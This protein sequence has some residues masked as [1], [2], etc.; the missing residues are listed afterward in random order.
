MKLSSKILLP[1]A[2]IIVVLGCVSVFIINASFKSLKEMHI[3][4]VVDS[5]FSFVLTR[6][7][8][9]SK[10]AQETAALFA[11]SP[12]VLE[13]FKIA[14]SGNID[15]ERSPQ[16]Q[17][18]REQIR[19]V[20]S[21]EL[22]NYA[23]VSGSK[24]RLHFHMPNGRSLVRLWRKKQAKRNG[25]WVDI[26]DDLS[27][28]RN[29]VLDVNTKGKPLGG[30]EL[31]RGGF[32]IRGLVPV[33]DSSGEIL[34]SA[35]VLNSFSPILK[36]VEDAGISTMLFM[37][38]DML[39]TA[40]SLR[41][42]SKYPIIGEDYVLVSGVDKA[43]NLS[44]VNKKLL[45]KS[46]NEKVVI[47]HSTDAVATLPIHDYRGNQI[48]VLVGVIDLQKMAAMSQQANIVLFAC[49]TAMLLIPLC[50]IFFTLRS[51]VVAPV[52]EIA[53]KINDINED[54][55]DLGTLIDIKFKDEIGYMTGQF[56][57][58]LGKISTMVNEMEIYVD[59]VNAVPDPIFVVDDEYN[60][61]FA[62]KGV[63]DFSGL[64]PEKIKK[65]KCKDIFNSDVCSTGKCPLEK[66][67]GNENSDNVGIVELE[68]LSGQTLY[69]QPVARS[70]QDSKGK[71]IGYLEVARNVTDLIIK[72]NN[73][74]EQ[75]N[76]INEVNKSTRV[77]SADIHNN[78]AELNREM[79]TVND[80]VNKQ[81]DLLSDTVVAFGQMNASILDVAENAS[82]A[83]GKSI[84]TQE[85]AEAGAVIVKNTSEA[86]IS[87]QKK[88]ESM[89]ETMEQLEGQAEVVG[90]VLNVI[91]DI[92]DQTNLLALNAAIEAA[93][94]GDAGRGFAVVADE[95]RKLAEKTV[96]ATKE[97]EEV[98]AG[99]QDQAKKSKKITA[100]T[101]ELAVDA[102]ESAAKSG[103]YLQSIVGLINESVSDVQNIAAAAEEQSASSEQI[104]AVIVEINELAVSVTERV[105]ESAN[106]LKSLVKLAEELEDISR[107]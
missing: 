52:K 12:D 26:S 88:T 50:M 40:T 58:L 23:A 21:P 44:V 64:S 10:S 104:N 8:D 85:K 18:A 69:V 77:A 76:K 98:I 20:L 42:E 11:A 43:E 72:E 65:S 25:K 45:D 73:I 39:S 31:G 38:K 102:A 56:N 49:V 92:A 66:I 96:D 7:N 82:R 70:L 47:V 62:N 79:G 41:D 29:T 30:I 3:H 106:S 14:H 67:K 55:A 105:K 60:V 16:A 84:E 13:A 28:F 22:K 61:L 75:L 93:R 5:A 81:Q 90:R 91:N 83:S 15:D 78:S 19:K 4:S 34:G 36:G 89:S 35:E 6:V 9:S 27:S 87:V 107:K 71:V 103:E 46:R 51:Q 86:I 2:F 80:A 53:E 63:S 37:N 33:K 100:E 32:A 99:I 1:Q 17:E 101:N 74:N 68:D 24:L 57:R 54:R 97:V 59:V 95:V 94:A 48:G